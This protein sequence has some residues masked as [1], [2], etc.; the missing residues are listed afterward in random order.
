MADH[1]NNIWKTTAYDNSFLC[2]LFLDENANFVK[3]IPYKGPI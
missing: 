3:N 2:F 1:V